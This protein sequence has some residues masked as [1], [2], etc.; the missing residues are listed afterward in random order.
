MTTLILDTECY[1]DYWLIGFRNTSTGNVRYFEMF[2]GQPLDVD[3]IRKIMS[4]YRTVGF[5]SKRYDIPMI[6]YA[7]RGVSCAQLKKASDTIIT[8]NLQPWQFEQQFGVTLPTR[9][10]HVDI[11][12]VAP[13]IASLKLYGGRLHARKLQDLPFDPDASITPEMRPLMREYNGNDLVTTQGLWESLLPQIDL[14]EA[15]SKT[16][17]QDLRS[18]SDAQIAEAVI[19]AQVEKLIGEKIVRPEIDA[20]TTFTYRA[21]GFIAYSSDVMREVLTIVERAPFMVE[22]SGYVKMPKELES[23]TIPLGSSAYRMGIGG[24]HSTE[25]SVHHLA[26]DGYSLIDRD[27][28]SYYPSIIL[29]SRLFPQQMGESFLTVYREIVRQRLAAKAAGDKV[30]ADVLKITINGS[31]GKFGSK[32]SSLYSPRLLIQ[33]TITGQL[34]LLMLIEMLEDEGIH[35]VSANTDGVVIRCHQRDQSTMDAIVAAWEAATGLTTE[36]AEYRA[37]YSRDVNNYVAVKPDGKVKLKGIF[38]P[39]GLSKNPTNEVCISAVVRYL[40]NGTDITE[41]IAGCQDVRKFV[42]VRTVKGG[43]VRDG[44]YL[45]K[46]VRWYYANNSPGVIS[47]KINGYTVPRSKGA[48]PL[49]ELS[50]ALPNDIDYGWYVTEA[51]SLLA[52]LGVVPPVSIC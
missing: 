10:D 7:M 13:G 44:Q 46:V 1:G 9:I 17:G 40:A 27:V 38:A 15:M 30:T 16:Y 37:L 31:F 14:R 21:P 51:N 32:W 52:G 45:G 35:V 41:T 29:N 18:K 23:R 26:V 33:T 5:N 50:D 11:I 4:T 49:M 8:R 42:S 47:Y 22:S 3:A 25:S 20:G 6:A 24:L 48:K 2:D 34:A 39:A 36:A 12:E 43:A 28:V 19:K